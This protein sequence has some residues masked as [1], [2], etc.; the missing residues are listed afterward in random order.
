MAVLKYKT[1]NGE[2]KTL[3]NYTI[4]NP[5]VVGTTG[6]SATDVMSQK[7]VTDELNKKMDSTEASKFVS[8]ETFNTEVTKIVNKTVYGNETPTVSGE[9]VTTE[10][11]GTTLSGYATQSWVGEQGYTKN[12]GT[13]TSVGVSV[14]TGLSVANS[15]VTTNGTIAISLATGYEIPQTT[16]LNSFLK[17]S[18]K[19][20]SANSNITNF[21]ETTAAGTQ[22]H[23]I[24]TNTSSADTTVTIPTSGYK[25]P[26]GQQMNIT[27]PKGGYAEVNLM[28]I[29][30]TTY[31][32]GL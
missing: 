19:V 32:R 29:E 28:N 15:P 10:N 20:V 11:L 6:E 17:G 3:L 7:A 24:Y 9:V 27:V 12:E 2:Y 13:V 30:G 14:P 5:N 4:K 8:S 31:V 18:M 26:D 1:A 25:T 21:N 22:L 23:I 16:T